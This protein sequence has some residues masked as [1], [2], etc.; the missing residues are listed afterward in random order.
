MMNNHGEK[1]A[2]VFFQYANTHNQIQ[3]TFVAHIYHMT[4]MVLR[5]GA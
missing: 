2:F 4:E 1:K 5:L 3:W